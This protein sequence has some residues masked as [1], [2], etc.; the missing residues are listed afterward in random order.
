VVNISSDIHP[1]SALENQAQKRREQVSSGFIA[2]REQVADGLV[3]VQRRGGAARLAG[4]QRAGDALVVL[5]EWFNKLVELLGVLVA[6][7]TDSV[8]PRATVKAILWGM[9][10]YKVICDWGLER[11]LNGR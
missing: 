1:I 6:W 8:D 7:V 9:V 2:V 4:Q 11:F 3:A 10:I 5:R